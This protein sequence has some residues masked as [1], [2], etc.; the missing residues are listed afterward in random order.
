MG[1]LT[2]VEKTSTIECRKCKTA[3]PVNFKFCD[4]C[5]QKLHRVKL[6]KPKKLKSMIPDYPERLPESTNAKSDETTPQSWYWGSQALPQLNGKLKKPTCD[7]P[8]HKNQQDPSDEELKS[9]NKSRKRTRDTSFSLPLLKPPV[10][11]EVPRQNIMWGQCLDKAEAEYIAKEA[12]LAAEISAN[13]KI[14]VHMEAQAQVH[15]FENDDVFKFACETKR[16]VERALKVDKDALK[17]VR[18]QLERLR[19]NKSNLSVLETKIQRMREEEER[20]RALKLKATSKIQAWYRRQ[21]QRRLRQSM[22]CIKV[23]RG[24]L[25]YR[26]DKRKHE[27][28]PGDF[29]FV[30]DRKMRLSGTSQLEFVGNP[31]KREYKHPYAFHLSNHEVKT[32]LKAVSRLQQF[33]RSRMSRWYRALQKAQQQVIQRARQEAMLHEQCAVRIQVL[34]R[35]RQ[36]RLRLQQLVQSTFEECVDPTTNMVFYYNRKTQQSQW[37]KPK[38]WRTTTSSA[39]QLVKVRHINFTELETPRRLTIAASIIQGLFRKRQ[40]RRRL[41]QI[42]AETYKKVFDPETNMFFYYNEKT[43]M[44]QWAKPTLLGSDD[45]QATPRPPKTAQV[46]KKDVFRGLSTP[47]RLELAATKLQGMFRSRLA[48]RRLRDLIAQT[49]QKVFDAGSKISYYYNTKTGESHWTK[50][51]LLGSSDIEEIPVINSPVCKGATPLIELNTPRRIELAAFRIQGLFRC[52]N[53]RRRLRLL[54]AQTYQKVLDPESREYYYY[55]IKTGESQW[56]KP[57]L[58]GVSDIDSSPG[59]A[60]TPR[61]QANRLATLETPRRF[62][63][64]AIRLQCL[65]RARNARRRL[66]HLIA[67]TFQKVLD[68]DSQQYYYYNTK[69]GES[70]WTKPV[71]LGDDDVDKPAR[72]HR[73]KNPRAFL[74]GLDEAQ[75]LIAAARKIQG[76]FRMRNAW[77]CLRTLIAETVKKYVDEDSHTCYYYNVRTGESSWTKPRL[78][79]ESDLDET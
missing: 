37:A 43:G 69:T 79:G 24:Y 73:K 66:R 3:C 33:F 48:R 58:L 36:A 41:K 19:G 67:Q 77:R 4:Q 30:Q 21:R 1:K 49:Y 29:Y 32:I 27:L 7:N 40:A 62:E 25:R 18:K 60:K 65:F 9:T 20:Q 6:K 11:S 34:F 31:S 59:T 39:P 38:W 17:D 10:S 14:L 72:H 2:T 16:K 15:A 8:S 51:M 78:L 22:L 75:Q 63:A 35:K 70:Q 55:N 47:R 74:S 5:G 12:L 45:I 42:I 57:K 56:N 76:L 28:F 64:A 71:L 46:E 68:A 61:P 23:C 54:I 44:S 52:R 26:Y 13:S 50:P 53:A